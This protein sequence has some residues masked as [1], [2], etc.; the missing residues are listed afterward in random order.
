M[1]K[2][3]SFACV[4]SFGLVSAAS[5]TPISYTVNIGA[6][7]LNGHSVTNVAIFESGGGFTSLDFGYTLNATGATTL[8]HDVS[9]LPTSTLIVGLD[10]PGP[11]GDNKTHLVFFTNPGFAAG[12]D[13]VLFSLAFPNT[14][15]NDFIAR[16]LS[17]ESGDAAQRDWLIAFL[18][19]DGAAAAFT[20]GNPTMAIEFT[21]GVVLPP[22]AVPE[23][24]SIMLLGLGLATAEA[25]RRRRKNGVR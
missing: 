20:P 2:T 24:A 22:T 15:H 8:T 9:F 23:P 16:L 25:V 18:A 19:G 14:H 17:A 10:F 3:A 5:A 12:A 1:I 6:G 13:G 21:G 11:V 7:A 4:L